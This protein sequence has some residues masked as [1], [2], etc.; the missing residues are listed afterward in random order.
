MKP[1]QR[2]TCTPRRGLAA[3]AADYG[4]QPEQLHLTTVPASAQRTYLVV[5]RLAR[6]AQVSSRW[7]DLTRAAF[8]LASSFGRPGCAAPRF[9]SPDRRSRAA[10]VL[11]DVFHQKA[12]G[13]AYSDASEKLDACVGTSP[14]GTAGQTPAHGSST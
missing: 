4:S 10:Y 9:R 6:S 14:T 3:G 5:L 12:R 2:S 13:P 11:T 8:D 7:A 1:D